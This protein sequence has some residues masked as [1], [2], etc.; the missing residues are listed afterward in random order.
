M[1][2]PKYIKDDRSESF[3]LLGDI[4][5]TIARVHG[6]VDVDEVTL[7]RWR[8]AMGLLREFDTLVDDDDISSEEAL[9]LLHDF[10]YFEG[11]YPH[12]D[13]ANLPN[14]SRKVMIARVAHILA[15]GE[16]ISSTKDPEEFYKYRTEEADHTALL[17][18]DS[19]TEYVKSQQGFDRRFIPIMQTLARTASYLDT[20]LDYEQDIIDGK[21]E[22]EKSSE[23]YKHLGKGAIKGFIIATP[24]LLHPSIVKDFSAMSVMRAKNRINYG[25]TP[26]SSA[27]TIAPTQ[28]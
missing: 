22:I 26:Y 15:L 5:A 28:R 6:R 12:L 14:D 2:A 3:S 1:E 21:V 19:A 17:L 4:S 27:N 23:L 25:R 7:N 24:R 20:V 9:D 8:D 10:E 18:S 11:R 13:K 16:G